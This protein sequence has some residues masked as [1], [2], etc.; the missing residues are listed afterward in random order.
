MPVAIPS[1]SFENPS[2][3]IR[4]LC[5]SINNGSLHIAIGF[6]TPLMVL[7]ACSVQ[8]VGCAAIC[9]YLVHVEQLSCVW[10]WFGALHCMKGM[11]VS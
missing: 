11:Q 2:I 3:D 6:C 8:S 7:Y 9:L 1:A 4:C 10:V 5:V